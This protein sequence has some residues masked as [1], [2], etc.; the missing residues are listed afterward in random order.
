MTPIMTAA[1]PRLSVK[2]PARPWFRLNRHAGV[3]SSLLPQIQAMLQNGILD[4]V[5]RDSLVPNFLFP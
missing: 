1:R 4:R 5:F 3:R 2:G